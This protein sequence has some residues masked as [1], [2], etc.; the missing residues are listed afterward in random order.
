MYFEIVWWKKMR[1]FDDMD[2]I[3]VFLNTATKMS[4]T[5]VL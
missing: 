4:V 5:G 2:I 1:S 3:S